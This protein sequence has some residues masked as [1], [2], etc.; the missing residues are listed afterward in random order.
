MI[1]TAFHLH[2]DLLHCGQPSEEMIEKA[3]RYDWGWLAAST[4]IQCPDGSLDYAGHAA[5]AA[6]FRARN[7]HHR[8]GWYVGGIAW[9]RPMDPAYLHLTDADLLHAPAPDGR[10]L[11]GPVTG[12]ATKLINLGSRAVQDRLIAFYLDFLEQH[13]WRGL[14]MDSFEPAFWAQTVATTYAMSAGCAEG[15]AHTV[16]WWQDALGSFGERL[17]WALAQRG[18]QTMVVGIAPYT[19]DTTNPYHAWMGK[20]NANVSDYAS[21]VMFEHV[22]KSYGNPVYFAEALAAIK[23][24]TDNR[25]NVFVS[26]SP[27][28]AAETGDPPQK[29]CPTLRRFYTALYLLVQEAPYTTGGYH[30]MT[31]YSAWDDGLAPYVFWDDDWALDLGAPLGPFAV[32]A[33]PLGSVWYRRYA[34]AIVVVNADLKYQQFASPGRFRLWDPV[35]GWEFDMAAAGPG[36]I[37]NIPPQEGWVLFHA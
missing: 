23:R 20:S 2:F 11:H 30:P 19:Y 17:R 7:P 34:R 4:D 10:P 9:Q 37:L 31:R 24:V 8:T 12:I 6:E 14:L 5:L 25:R 18:H 16:A 1:A 29:D 26:V 22:H 13:G 33:G 35:A 21:G 32:Q 3:S 27:R 36:Y 15:P 28:L